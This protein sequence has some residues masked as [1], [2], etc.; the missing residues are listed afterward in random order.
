MAFEFTEEQEIFRREIRRFA[1]TE[2]AP[3]A[4]ERAK[5]EP[6]DAE[7][8]RK[9]L[10]K[11]A[12]AGF[13]GVGLASEYGGQGGDAI[14]V[15]IA[16]EEI[17]KVDVSLSLFPLLPMV[18]Y[19]ALRYA[20][21]PEE[22]MAE[23]MPKFTQG[24]AVASFALTEPEAGADAAAIRMTAVRDGDYYILNG[25]K[26][27][28]TK[29][30][31]ADA[32]M[33]FAKT[34]P[35]AGIRGITCFWVPL[36]L[37]GIARSLIPHTGLKFWGAASIIFE[38]VRLPAE[39]RCGEEGKGFYLFGEAVNTQRA[40]LGLLALG[41]AQASIDETINYIRQRTAFGH[42]LSSF[43]GVAFKIAEHSTR[44]EAA[45]LLCYKTLSLISR[46]EFPI[47]E[48]A[49]C[50]WWCPEVALDTVHDCLLLHGHVAY[51]EEYPIE[52]R[53][54]DII[55]LQF[56]DSLPQ[57]MKLVVSRQLIGREAASF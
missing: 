18:G 33:L 7:Y 49:M 47:K 56:T 48:A 35:K 16:I 21:K 45:R 29:G 17:G 41:I 57:I 51:S 27:S 15:G 32:S 14:M 42:P 26:T 20:G 38:D 36:N 10:K 55:G 40:C 54:R 22:L 5:M 31:Y 8:R 6:T 1:Q 23:W 13:L 24:E 50:K 39:N 3:T 44:V 37:P 28:I 43:E 52:Q 53:L 19:Y 11:L 30:V 4:K 12:D 34:D 2:L 46:G 9:W 25:E